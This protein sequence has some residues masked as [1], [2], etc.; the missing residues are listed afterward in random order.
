MSDIQL[1]IRN[2]EDGKDHVIDCPADLKVMDFLD[3][4]IDGLQ[5]P[6]GAWVLDDE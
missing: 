6:S 4:L 5:L 2:K 3:E 1:H